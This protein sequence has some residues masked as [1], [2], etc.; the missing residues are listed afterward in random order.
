MN[1]EEERQLIE[2]AQ[3]GKKYALGKLFKEYYPRVFGYLRKRITT[4]ELAEDL[5]ARTFEKV[6]ENLPR[7]K[8]RKNTSFKSWVFQIATN[9]MRQYYRKASTKR[10]FASEK[11]EKHKAGRIVPDYTQKLTGEQSAKVLQHAIQNLPQADQEILVLRFFEG[12]DTKEIAEIL[13]IRSGAVSTRL[14]RAL[15]RVRKE[16]TGTEELSPDDAQK[17]DEYIEAYVRTKDKK[18]R[19][20][21]LALIPL[22][23][24][25][26]A[27]IIETLTKAGE[28]ISGATQTVPTAL[29]NSLTN[30]LTL[31]P[32]NTIN[33]FTNLTIASKTAAIVASL[34]IVAT[35]ATTVTSGVQRGEF[36]PAPTEQVTEEVTDVTDGGSEVTEPGTTTV[37][38]KSYCDDKFKF[39]FDYPAEWNNPNVRDDSDATNYRQVKFTKDGNESLVIDVNHPGRGGIGGTFLGTEDITIAGISAE[40]SRY[41]VDGGRVNLLFLENAHRNQYIIT[42]SYD[43]QLMSVEDGQAEFT[44]LIESW[45]FNCSPV[46]DATANWKTYPDKDLGVTLRYPGNW[47]IEDA[48]TSTPTVQFLDDARPSFQQGVLNVR[49]DTRFADI[50]A[51]RDFYDYEDSEMTI[52][53][54]VAYAFSEDAAIRTIYVF[55]DGKTYEIATNYYDEEDIKLAIESIEFLD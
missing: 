32:L 15:K 27:D 4:D 7:F 36:T 35:T 33:M 1:I 30:Q 40:F 28:T 45:T 47:T 18:E 50:A 51:A 26:V 10:E 13:N 3:N 29:L 2:E 31:N 37:A 20:K 54:I 42:H 52:D 55:K 14:H 53:G 19:K 6:V 48:Q 5:S 11:P 46:A 38:T 34:A 16:I 25:D 17:M 23:L 22:P 43:S 8:A 39:G 49:I 24:R 21:L 12:F 9:E 41:N 44:A